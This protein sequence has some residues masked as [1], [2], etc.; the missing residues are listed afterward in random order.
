MHQERT[1][2]VGKMSRQMAPWVPL[3][4]QSCKNNLNEKHPFTPFQFSTVEISTN[5]DGTEEVKPCVRTVVLRDFLFN[6]KKTN[7]LT[8]NTDLRS[9]KMN[10]HDN[11]RHFFESCFYFPGTWEQYR[12][13]GEWFCVSLN[14]ENEIADSK[15]AKYGILIK[16]VI[17][18]NDKTNKITSKTTTNIHTNDVDDKNNMKEIEKEDEGEITDIIYR[19]PESQDWIDEVMREWS[20]LSRGAKS[21]YR[22][23]PPGEIL[24]NETSKKLDKIQRGVD[25]AKEDAGLENFGVMCLCID[26]VDYLNLKDGRGG[27]R[28]V[29]KRCFDAVLSE[30]DLEDEHDD[31]TINNN[32]NDNDN[33]DQKGEIVQE[34]HEEGVEEKEEEVEEVCGIISGQELW[35]EE[36]VCP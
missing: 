27:E 14:G 17:R 12:L 24:T 10:V 21:L 18:S 20:S 26:K 6:D 9:G 1:T 32:D 22:K 15:L 3:F 2:S 5:E 19:F 29:F 8:F 30:S 4:Q 16:E 11:Q 33:D 28:R 13:S 34:E 23:P 35:T 31:T 25:G 36:E 7:V